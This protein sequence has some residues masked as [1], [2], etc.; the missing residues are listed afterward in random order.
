M[1]VTG[2][3][4]ATETR[5]SVKICLLELF[6]YTHRKPTAA[7]QDI[8]HFHL[9]RV[10]WHGH[11]IIGLECGVA[12]VGVGKY[13][14]GV[15]NGTPRQQNPYLTPSMFVLFCNPH[16]LCPS[17]LVLLTLSLS[18]Y[19]NTVPIPIMAVTLIPCACAVNHLVPLLLLLPLLRSATLRRLE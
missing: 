14:K 18:V 9:Q 8:F 5:N 10:F 6:V 11:H 19:L 2:T 15:V 16:P 13:S 17:P 7:S 3:V 1:R 12:A 4:L